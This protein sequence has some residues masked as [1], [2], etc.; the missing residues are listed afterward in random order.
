MERNLLLTSVSDAKAG[1]RKLFIAR[2]TYL[3]EKWK[4][5]EKS[6]KKVGSDCSRTVHKR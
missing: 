6:Q 1:G 4:L 2:K 3:G 5:M